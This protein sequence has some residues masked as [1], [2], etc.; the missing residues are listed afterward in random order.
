MRWKVD[1]IQGRAIQCRSI[2][3]RI[4]Q[5][6]STDFFLLKGIVAMK[7]IVQKGASGI[8]W[9]LLCFCALILQSS[10]L[11]GDSS[12][13]AHYLANEGVMVVH[14]DTK[15]VF[16]PLFN[17]DYGRYQLLPENMKQALYSGEAPYNDIDAVFV[18]HSHQDHFSPLD[19]LKLMRLRQGIVLYAPAQAVDELK[20]SAPD[21]AIFKRV[22]GLQLAYGDKP[23]VYKTNDL[24]IEA[25][26]IPHSGWPERMLDV[27]NIAFRITLQNSTTVLHLGDADT[28]DAHYE[29][30]AEYW[31]EREIDMAFPPYWYFSSKNGQHVLENRLRPGHAV[32]IHVPTAMPAKVQ[33]RPEDFRD[34]DLFTTPGEIRVIDKH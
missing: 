33:D 3:A 21:D 1:A 15:V 2:Q 12:A 20:A 11:L 22:T 9:R 28:K 25:V 29:G 30:D 13:T 5:N 6:R 18:S 8:V 17:N 31:N 16:D 24:I 19:M 4:S 7:R 34:R 14:G 26:Y 10:L 32:G 27:Q 23:V